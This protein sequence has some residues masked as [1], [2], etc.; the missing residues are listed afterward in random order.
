MKKYK[1]GYTT[2]VFDL[3]HIGHLNILKRAKEQCE[4]LIVG[5]STDELVMSYKNKTP[6]IP[7]EERI[8]IV[9]SI[10]YVDKVVA[11]KDRDKLKAFDEIGFDV[12]FVGDDWKNDK[13]FVEVEKELHKKN[14]SI[15][16]FPYTQGTSST[17]IS[18]IL[19]EK[20][21]SGKEK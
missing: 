18:Q 13:L 14:A 7:F 5:V 21:E 4:Y 1:I 16:F 19:H 3:F 10:K 6:I 20:L 11:Q 8:Q 2:G 15:V 9:E 17:I 12:M